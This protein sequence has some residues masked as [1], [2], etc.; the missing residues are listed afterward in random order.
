MCPLV[1]HVG[2]Q[3]WTPGSAPVVIADEGNRENHH[4]GEGRD[5][6]RQAY[7]PSIAVVQQPTG[8]HGDDRKAE[9]ESFDRTGIRQDSCAQPKQQSISPAS[10]MHDPRQGAQHHCAPDGG[11][12]ST[13]IAVHPVVK[14]IETQQRYQAAEKRP[15]RGEPALKHPRESS[16]HGRHTQ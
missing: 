2:K 1:H 14:E 3:E 15:H 11:Y 6:I 16:T 13:P 5:K 8:K 7:L 10:V 12:R 9:Q 4:D